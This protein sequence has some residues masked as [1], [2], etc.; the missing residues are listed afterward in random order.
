MSFRSEL[1]R[2]RR[3][4]KSKQE[5]NDGLNT[6]KFEIIVLEILDMHMPI[7]RLSLTLLDFVSDLMDGLIEG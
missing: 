6:E 7:M 4:G 5:L 1:R 3:Q 2:V